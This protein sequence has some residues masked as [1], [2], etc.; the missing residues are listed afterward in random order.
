MENIEKRIKELT[1]EI[2]K[3][4]YQYYTLDNPLISDGEYDKLFD[5]LK[6]LEKKRGYIDPNSPT[7]RVGGQVL[8]GFETHTHLRP[9]YS[10]DKAKSIEEVDQWIGR[11]NRLIEEE[12]LSP[13][14]YMIE[15][16]FDGLSIKLT[17]DDGRLVSA[18]TRGNGIVGEEILA[19]VKTI[20]SIP[21]EIPYKGL[22]EVVGEGVMPI[23]KFN[24]YNER[25]ETPLKNPRNAAAGALRN[26]DTAVTRSR[27]LDAFFYSVNYIEDAPYQTHKE[28]MEFLRDNHFKVFPYLDKKKDLDG[29]HQAIDYIDDHRKTIDVL[30]DGV[31]IKINDMRTRQAL[32]FTQRAPRWAIAFKFEA[33]EFT[34]VLRKVQW[35]VGRTGKVTPSAIVDPV[36]IEGA[37]V[38]RATLNNYDDIQRKNLSL[39]DRVLIRRSNDVIPEILGSV[40]KTEDSE[41]ILMP[42]VC[43]ACG[44]ELIKDGVHSFCPNSLSCRPQLIASLDHFAS[45][46]AMDIDGLSEKTITQLLAV[47]GL[48]EMSQI[49]TLT[50]EDLY[51]LEGFKEKKTRNLLN[52]IEASK[53]V[54]LEKFIYALGIPGIGT[55]TAYDLAK[56]FGSL[57]KLRE[58]DMDAL[59]KLDD[60]GDITAQAIVEFFHDDHIVKGLEDLLDQGIRIKNP[61]WET[62]DSSLSGKTIVIT[63]SFDGY[64]RNDLKDYFTKLGAKVTGSVS[65][66][67]DYVLAG[68][69]AGSK[70]TR[71]QDLG[72]EIITKDG[73][74]E[75]MRR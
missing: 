67:T 44:T 55:K 50:E 60:I 68:D 30:T 11:T 65:S 13:A 46:D 57:D 59:V 10:L 70:L 41:P 63:G 16:K 27:M 6:D 31:V 58:A 18:A 39:Y 71:A 19:N 45:R 62:K 64:T 5:E 75:F 72:T 15:Y 38:R 33:E 42:K 34:T 52:A 37:T 2:N 26:L 17:Y 24:L 48:D 56:S 8:E 69:K 32:G 3:H 25:E 9:L 53:E 1:E 66:N 7:Q 74:E 49:Y 29:I 51:K 40:E 4:N 47:L 21:L 12:S 28:M 61:S 73:L 14:E 23:S 43:P 35:N 22:I 20:M 54:D 36:E